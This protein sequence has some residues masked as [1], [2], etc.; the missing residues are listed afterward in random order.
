MDFQSLARRELQALCKKNKIPANLTNIAMVDALKALEII[1]GIEDFSKPC[2]SETA[3]SSFASPCG[4]RTGCRTS[5]RRKT[6]KEEPESLK[7]LTR[8]RLSTRRT[9]AGDVE[10]AKLDVPETPAMPSG[11]KRAPAASARRKIEAQLK[12]EDEDKNNAVASA[13]RKMETPMREEI[14]VQK[15]YSTRRSTRLLEKK[16]MELDLNK[17]EGIEPVHFEAY[18]EMPKD[19]ARNQ[20]EESD[21]FDKA[22]GGMYQ[23]MINAKNDDLKAVSDEMSKDLERNVKEDSDDLDKSLEVKGENQQIIADDILLKTDDLEAIADEK[24]DVLSENVSNLEDDVQERMEVNNE[25]DKVKPQQISEVFCES[26]TALVSDGQTDR[27][28][29]HKDEDVDDGA[30]GENKDDENSQTKSGMDCEKYG[31]SHILSGE[32]LEKSLGLK[33][34]IPEEEGCNESEF[35]SFRYGIE[36]TTECLMS[37]SGEGFNGDKDLG[38]KDLAALVSSGRVWGE[39]TTEC[40]MSESREGFNSDKDLVLQGLVVPVV[41]DLV[42][43]SEK[44]E[45]DMLTRS[46]SAAADIEPQNQVSKESD[47]NFV[48]DQNNVRDLKLG[49]DTKELSHEK[50]PC[51]VIVT[52]APAN[53][54]AMEVAID[55][56]VENDT[57]DQLAGQE[58]TIFGNLIDSANSSTISCH[59][60]DKTLCPVIATLASDSLPVQM[61]PILL[62]GGLNSDLVTC[63]ASPTQVKKSSS[64]KTPTTTRRINNLLVDNKENNIDNSSRKLDLTK[65]KGMKD[66]KKPVE[67][68]NDD[69]SLRQLRKIFKE[70]LQITNNKEI[71]EEKNNT[72]VERARPALQT[73]SENRLAESEPEN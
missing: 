20:K 9:I 43:D 23:Q 35:D 67:I 30:Y 36:N 51:P 45:S 68:F 3:E 33:D 49:P 38:L 71:N 24:S 52:L 65:E 50:T 58:S 10:N 46:A 39:N 66:K 40:L 5:T 17:K 44:P 72:K 14:S 26:D 55:A 7:I 42:T 16:M 59:S 13:H 69:T 11:R 32:N 73:L 15:V 31:E 29:I 60:L 61:Q 47:M 34:E 21:E 62:Q 57:V 18:E 37:E 54:I 48:N 70:K 28:T 25:V 12:E 4:P 6:V 53:S 22:L 63:P 2:E 8:T 27:L 19:L 1:E 64:K 41:K 56:S